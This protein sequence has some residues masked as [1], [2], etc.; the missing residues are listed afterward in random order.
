VADSIKAAGGTA[1]PVKVNVSDSSSVNQ[2]VNAVVKEL[3]GVDIL[4]NNAGIVTQS[5]VLEQTDEEW[6]R[7]LQCRS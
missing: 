2:M 7:I 4:V 6:R 3:G 5:S 1:Y